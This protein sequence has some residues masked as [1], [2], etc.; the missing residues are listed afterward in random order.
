MAVSDNRALAHRYYWAQ[1][2]LLC[3]A[4]MDR[5]GR[6]GRCWAEGICVVYRL[7]GEKEGNKIVNNYPEVNGIINYN[8]ENNTFN[9]FQCEKKNMF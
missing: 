5:R 9:A 4:E 2:E 7:P 3:A 6:P 1:A 8:T